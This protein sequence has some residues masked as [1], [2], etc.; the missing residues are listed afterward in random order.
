MGHAGF[1]VL[2]GPRRSTD[3]IILALPTWRR[4]E[5]GLFLALQHPI[6]LPGV[7]LLDLFE[8]SL[9]ARDH[10][11]RALQQ[12]AAAEARELGLPADA[13]DQPVNVGASGGERKRLETLQLAVLE[14]AIAILDELD[15]GLDVDAM[16]E[17]ARRIERSV[18]PKT[19]ATN[20]AQPLGVLAITHYNRLLTELHPDRVHVLVRGVIVESG[21]PELALELERTGYTP[22][23][24]GD[25][26]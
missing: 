10:D 25:L 5:L 15:S 12:R 2:A 14:P 21:G 26:T 18:R 4:A 1:E 16:R 9:A 11:V 22:Y 23:L 13:I 7:R 17:V 3:K 6:E 24:E 8:A 19:Q 20:G